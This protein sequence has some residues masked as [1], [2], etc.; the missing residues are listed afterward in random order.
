MTTNN[1]GNRRS[2]Y[3][4]TSTCPDSTLRASTFANVISSACAYAAAHSRSFGVDP[5]IISSFVESLITRTSK[6]VGASQRAASAEREA[7]YF[8]R[9]S[10]ASRAGATSGRD[11]K[12]MGRVVSS[13]ALGVTSEI[14]FKTSSAIGLISS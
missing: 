12:S 10:S 8:A 3:F 7:Q 11:A 9:S 14:A 13:T 2:R 6:R 1:V 5:H 4:G